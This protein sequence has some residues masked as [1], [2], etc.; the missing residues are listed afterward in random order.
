MSPTHKTIQGIKVP[1][2]GFGTYE[3]RDEVC[4]EAVRTA[5]ET[6]YRHI[7][8]ARAYENE[9]SVGAGLA[10]SGILRDE[11]FLVSKIWFDDLRYDAVVREVEQSLRDL[12]TDYLDLVL[13]H[14]PNADIPLEQTFA[15]LD[16]LQEGE[17]IR[18]FGVSNFTPELLVKALET[19]PVFCNQVECHPLL[20]QERLRNMAIEHDLLLTAYSPLAQ[21]DVHNNEVLAAIGKKHGATAEQVALR[22]LLDLDHVAAIPRSRNREHI[23]DNFRATE[24]TLDEDDY[25][26]IDELPDTIRKVDPDFAP[27]WER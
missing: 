10:D 5:I 15:A 21:G 8:T 22:W 27:A 7:D 1:S 4:Q 2:L 19:G 13:V 12:Q 11:I 23:R 16:R 17:I 24:L 6:G 18:R 25:R 9:Q 20:R 3:L 26:R 14:W